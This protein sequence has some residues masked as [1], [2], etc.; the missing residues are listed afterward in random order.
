VLPSTIENSP[1]ALGEAMLLGVPCVASDVGGVITMM[2][3]G[4][5]GYV[6]PSTAPYML[7]HYIKKIFAQAEQAA[8]LGNEARSHARR[9]HDPEKNLRDLLAIY[10]EIS[11]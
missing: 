4:T 3:H 5:E 2:N 9:I 6:Y 7:A 8:A 1:N 11:G 10:H